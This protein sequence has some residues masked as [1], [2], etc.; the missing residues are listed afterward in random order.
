MGL[1][2]LLDQDFISQL[3]EKK[4]LDGAK[5]HGIF[6]G[7][8]QTMKGL[9]APRYDAIWDKWREDVTKQMED[10]VAWKDLLPSVLNQFLA[11][12]DSIED[13]VRIFREAMMAKQSGRT[14]K[15]DE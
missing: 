3:I 9:H 1:D 12:L 11:K 14:D 10:G 6:I 13:E 15:T 7:I 4:L 2:E 8:W 5:F